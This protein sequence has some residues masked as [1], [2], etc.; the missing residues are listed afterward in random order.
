MRRHDPA[1]GEVL[2]DLVRDHAFI[3]PM[4]DCLELLL[5]DAGADR[6]VAAAERELAGIA[7]VL[8]NH[9]AYEER[10]L[11]SVLDTLQ[12]EAGSGDEGLLR[13]PLDGVVGLT[14]P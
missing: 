12:V 13:A 2:D 8:E 9:L 6:D 14:D 4:L 5:A 3:D 7:A 1:L 11:V 10:V